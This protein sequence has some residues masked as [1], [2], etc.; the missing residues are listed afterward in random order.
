MKRGFVGRSVTAVEYHK[1]AGG[2]LVNGEVSH[3][4]IEY[5][6]CLRVGKHDL[7]IDEPAVGDCVEKLRQQPHTVVFD[8]DAVCRVL[9]LKRGKLVGV[10]L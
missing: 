3:V 8:Y 10:E 9:S 2:Q 1:L 6:N 7:L 5:L 4:C